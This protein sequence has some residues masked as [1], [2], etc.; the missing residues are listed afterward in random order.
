M[1]E[2]TL[3]SLLNYMEDCAISHSTSAGYGVNEL[4]AADAGWVLYR[5]LIKIDRLPKLGE[6]ITVQTWASSFERFYG[7]RE[8]IVLDGRDNPIVKASSVWIYFNIKKRKPMRI[9]L[10]MGDAYG[11]DETRAL[12]EPFTDFDF[13]FEP[14]V[15]EEFTVKR[16][17]IDTNSHVNN[18]KYVDWIMETVPQQIY[19][20]YK[21][22]SLQIIYKKESSLGSGIKAG[23]VIDE[24]N[25][26]NPRLLH[27]I[28]DKNTGL[29]LV[30]AETIWQKIQS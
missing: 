29:E 26:D 7:N 25:T 10:E 13:D 3:L 23:C 12:E 21:V 22:T 17:D 28:W 6:T 18:K 11:I 19:D 30:S 4:L 5:W 15:I 27:K 16:S 14:K 9:P 20:N 2:A 1:Q 24:Q 8:F